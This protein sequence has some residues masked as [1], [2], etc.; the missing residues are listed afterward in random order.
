MER[1]AWLFTVL[2]VA[3]AA[4]VFFGA[5]YLLLRVV[6]TGLLR[7]ELRHFFDSPIAWLVMAGFT[8]V[9]GFVFLFLADY[10]TQTPNEPLVRVFFGNGFFWILQFIVIPAITMR[11]IAEERASGTLET[12]M[13]A[14]VTDAEVVFSKFL[15]AFVFYVVM[16]LPTLVLLGA[17][18]HYAAPELFYRDLWKGHELSFGYARHVWGK[19]N[20]V[21]DL[22][23][24]GAA[25]LGVFLMGAAWIGIGLLASSLARNQVVAFIVGFVA[26]LMLFSIGF[27]E[28]L[29]TVDPVWLPG[30]R[31]VLHYLSFSNAFDDFPRGLVDTRSVVYFVSLTVFSLFLATRVVESRKWR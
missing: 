29:I 19:V 20:E 2:A 23:P 13:T 27:L 7:K 18:Y 3:L 25:Y 8:F 14:P 21:M 10:Y 12:L 26:L 17:A 15:A 9:N 5:L 1:A 30:L 28:N 16:W 11:L 24:V 31:E 22:G 6:R 4:A